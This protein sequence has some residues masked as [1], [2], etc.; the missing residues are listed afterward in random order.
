MHHMVFDNEGD[1]GL[2]METT[3]N[4]F[5]S[6]LKGFHGD[7]LNFLMTL[8]SSLIPLPDVW[9]IGSRSLYS[10]ETCFP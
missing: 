2:S 1:L 9:V 7:D 10:C 3:N 6:G 5:H 4:E 8:S